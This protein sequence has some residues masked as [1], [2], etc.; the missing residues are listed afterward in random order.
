MIVYLL[1]VGSNI[2]LPVLVPV[3]S[4]HDKLILVS[5][6]KSSGLSYDNANSIE[7]ELPDPLVGTPG[8]MFPVGG[9]MTKLF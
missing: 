9:P 1:V 2:I 6:T 4:L 5:V 8:T 3:L 7:F